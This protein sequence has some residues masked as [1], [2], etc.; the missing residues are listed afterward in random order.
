MFEDYSI[1]VQNNQ[2]ILLYCKNRSSDSVDDQMLN[3]SIDVA[4]ARLN[5]ILLRL[6][7]H[8]LEADLYH[9]D[10]IE[11]QSAIE[12]FYYYLLKMDSWPKITRWFWRWNLDRIGKNKIPKIRNLLNKIDKNI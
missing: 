10:I 1:L 9:K 8:P 3:A 6:I 2:K 11:C 5:T 12:K 4:L 7:Q